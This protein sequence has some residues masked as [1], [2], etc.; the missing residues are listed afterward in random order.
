MSRFGMLDFNSDSDNES[1]NDVNVG[2]E[3]VQDTTGS[4]IAV[5][6][7]EKSYPKLTIGNLLKVGDISN[8]RVDNENNAEDSLL[9]TARELIYNMMKGYGKINPIDRMNIGRFHMF[10]DYMSEKTKSFFTELYS[11]NDG[12]WQGEIASIYTW[13]YGKNPDGSQIFLYIS[14]LESYGSCS[15]CDMVESLKDQYYDLVH[16]VKLAMKKI[17]ILNGSIKQEESNYFRYNDPIVI[18]TDEKQRKTMIFD[19]K[20][21][22][23]DGTIAIREFIDDHIFRT[24]GNLVIS[25]SY[26]DAVAHIRSGDDQFSPPKFLTALKTAF[27]NKDFSHMEPLKLPGQR[28]KHVLG[29]YIKDFKKK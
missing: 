3:E 19:L 11:E 21:E 7:D 12:D 23:R 16:D 10:T 24:V 6:N 20:K 2:E 17:S 14:T 18:P 25:R 8:N 15:G 5:A 27:P 22:I 13:R 4:E 28:K 29:N 9:K 1:V 26:N